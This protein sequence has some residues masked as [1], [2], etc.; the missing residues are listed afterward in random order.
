[1]T[2]LPPKGSFR[3]RDCPAAL[4]TINPV[5]GGSAIRQVSMSNALLC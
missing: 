4:H 2:P 3:R 5:P 1:M